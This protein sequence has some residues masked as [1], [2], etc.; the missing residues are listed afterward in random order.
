MDKI[1]KQFFKDYNN[2]FKT[3][4]YF[5]FTRYNDEKFKA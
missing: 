5:F 3:T 1:F 4:N 2:F